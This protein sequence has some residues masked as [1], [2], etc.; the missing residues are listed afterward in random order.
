VGTY[1]VYLQPPLPHQLP[2]GTAAAPVEYD[3]PRA[4]QDPVQ[5]PVT[6]DVKAGS[7]TIVIEF[8]APDARPE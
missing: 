8:P 7:N 4:F 6:Q 5:T 3:I 1:K 2:P